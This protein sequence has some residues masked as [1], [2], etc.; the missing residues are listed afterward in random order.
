MYGDKFSFDAI[1]DL[2]TGKV[3]VQTKS[4]ETAV[5]EG[6]KLLNTAIQGNLLQRSTGEFFNKLIDNTKTSTLRDLIAVGWK[7]RSFAITKQV[8]ETI[9]ERKDDVT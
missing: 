9:E 5:I 3:K 1:K 2:I 6:Y 4:E 7:G 8:E